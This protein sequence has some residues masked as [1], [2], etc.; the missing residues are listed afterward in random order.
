MRTVE[1]C[2]E[3]VMKRC[4]ELA[5]QRRRKREFALKAAAPVCGIAIIAGSIAAYA[6]RTS[7]SSKPETSNMYADMELVSPGMVD[8]RTADHLEELEKYSD[9][10]VVGEFIDD[11]VSDI[12][13]E[14]SDFFGK[15]IIT[16]ARSYNVIEVKQVLMGDVKVG[17]KLTVTQ[18]EGS[19]DGKM[20]SWSELTPMTKGDEWI[21]FLDRDDKDHYWVTCD[22]DGRF[23]TKNSAEKNRRMTFKNV[24]FPDSYQLGVYDKQSFNQSIYDEIVEKYDV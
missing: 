23:P 16:L 22:S 6:A 3:Y 11:S 9:I 15:D 17:D 24:D 2:Y 5:A 1:E 12:E 19:V 13:Y 20:Y 7:Y 4:G 21:F 10:A 8:R 18:L 14:Y